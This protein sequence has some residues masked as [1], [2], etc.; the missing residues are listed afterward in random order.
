[1]K[2]QTT[3][4][5]LTLFLFLL[6]FS[7]PTHASTNIQGIVLDQQNEAI[8]FANVLLLQK[9]DSALIKGSITTEDGH[10]LIEKVSPGEYF[11]SVSV[12][13][14][15]THFIE[16]KVNP[17]KTEIQVAA[18]QLEEDI[19]QLEAVEIRARKP[20]F[21]Q[22]IDRMVVNV[23]NSITSAGGSALEVLEKSPGVIVNQQ[24]NSISMGGK[25]GVVIMING[26]ESRMPMEAAVQMLRSMPAENL[27]KIELITTPPAKFDAEGNAGFINIILKKSADYG[28]NGSYALSTG[29][30]DAEKYGGSLN[31]N[32]RTGKLNL[33]GDYS[34]SRNH[35][36]QTFGNYRSI[37]FQGIETETISD[38]ERDPITT[39]HN[40]RLGLDLNLSDKTIFGALLSGYDSKWEM[41]AFNDIQLLQDQVPS[42]SM[43][44]K[45]HEINHWR[46]L[47]GNLNLQHTISPGQT[48]SFDVDYLYYHDNNPTDYFNSLFDGNG[49]FLEEEQFRSSKVTPIRIWVGKIDY[50]K[51]FGDHIKLEAGLKGTRSRFEND[52]R[53]E[54]LIQQIW[55]TDPTLT[56][57]A[58]LKEDITAAYSSLRYDIN[59]KTTLMAG[60]RYEY[61]TSNLSSPE[62][63]DIVDRQ[64]G[65]F[66]PTL[67][68]SQKINDNHSL[69][70]SYNRRI[71]RPTFNDLAPFVIFLDPNTFFSGN[72][73]LQPA[74][75]NAVKVDYRLKSWVFSTSYSRENDAISLFQPQ[76][77][78]ES[79]KQ[80]FAAANLEYLNTWTNMVSFPIYVT[81]WWEMQNN[82]MLISQK[83]QTTIEG[84]PIQFQQNTFS[85]NSAQSFTLPKDFSLEVSGFY[86]SAALFGYM[87]MKAMGSFNLGLQKKFKDDSS[88]RFAFTDIF[89]TNR[90]TFETN[91]PEQNLNSVTYVNFENR[92]LTLTYTR[93]FG[94]NKLKASRNRTT[95]SEEE[96]RRVTK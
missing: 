61:T 55:Q 66:Y 7:L 81:N 5:A 85:F 50:T 43:E 75:T 51:N 48:L 36:Y 19:A 20:L 32:H 80:F 29:Y 94:N 46:H 16:L 40:A 79:N 83:S 17:L 14:Y 11:L 13:G 24:N 72:S 87:K 21:E 38:S 39:L 73:A 45:N 78:P 59:E 58:T 82:A 57:F 10:Y 77:D 68:L 23:E 89:R 54:N 12:L 37:I 63:P 71:T 69:Q 6:F 60:L 86:R 67:F 91:V 4:G 35:S 31:F 95:G 26:K 88:L 18:I 22:Q 42:R 64:Y 44:I 53:V 65:N 1:M 76:V 52:V 3:Y 62:E 33:Y 70:F 28:T 25:S 27:Q 96:R 90:W 2:T 92:K 47:M 84:V 49:S 8:A 34:Y 15:K 74:I 56:Q 30:G 41:D 93:S 9:Q